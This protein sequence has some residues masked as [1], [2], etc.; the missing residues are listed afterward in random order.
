MARNSY[1]LD[2][3]LYEPL[4]VA[5]ASSFNLITAY[6]HEL[7]AINAA[8][9]KSIKALD[10][11][12]YTALQSISGIG[13]VFAAGILSELGNI[14]SFKDNGARA[15]YAG[16]VWRESQSGNFR[17]EDTVMSK[18][19]NTYL[20]YYLLEATNSV[21]RHEPNFKKYYDHK[22]EEVKIHNYTRAFA[23][24]VCKFVKVSW[25]VKP[26]LSSR[27]HL[28]SFDLGY[29]NISFKKFFITSSMLYPNLIK[30]L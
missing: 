11:N 28:K 13:P 25:W 7:K 30:Y 8:I 6:N 9:E 27:F 26:A 1:R 21:I 4:T 24:N 18:A 2:K 19:G 15:K 12:A 20:R 14:H 5:I 23:L 16:L 10:L 29:W 17:A 22:F 3:V